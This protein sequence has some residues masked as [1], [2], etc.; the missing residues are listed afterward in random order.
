MQ[1]GPDAVERLRAAMTVF[2]HTASEQQ[3]NALQIV[4]KQAYKTAIK[5]Y[6]AA[7]KANNAVTRQLNAAQ[8]NL[9]NATIKLNSLKAG[10][11]AATAA[12]LAA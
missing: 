2:N 5:K 11:D 10:L 3:Q 1:Q 9:T 4:L 6:D 12:T 8:A 7:L